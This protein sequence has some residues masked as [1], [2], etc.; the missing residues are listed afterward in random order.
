MKKQ[1]FIIIILILLCLGLLACGKKDKKEKSY[2]EHLRDAVDKAGDLSTNYQIQAIKD[3]VN[4]Y[5]ID[6]G[7]YPENLDDLVPGY[8][9]VETQLI[10]DYG[11]K[12]KIENNEIISAGRDKLFDTADDIKW[13]I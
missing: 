13:E 3:A 11:T 5:N 9:K 10:D 8:L 2:S 6:N 7:A 1:T 12:F 4:S